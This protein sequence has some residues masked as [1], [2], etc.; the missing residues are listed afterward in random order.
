M[1]FTCI[2]FPIVSTESRTDI[3]LEDNRVRWEQDKGLTSTCCPTEPGETWRVTTPGWWPQL[4]VWREG[5]GS[6]WTGTP[7]GCCWSVWRG[8]AGGSW[9]AGRRSPPLRHSSSRSCPCW[10]R[11]TSTATWPPISAQRKQRR[12]LWLQILTGI[13][14]AAAF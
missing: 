3:G 7:A 13:G 1:M 10:S 6:G 9:W 4:S 14:E 2:S 8:E 12:T 5:R 11:W